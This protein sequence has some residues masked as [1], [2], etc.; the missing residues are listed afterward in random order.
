MGVVSGMGRGPMFPPRARRPANR[1]ALAD[2]EGV[3]I[4]ANMRISTI[5]VGETSDLP[6][7]GVDGD[8]ILFYEN[9]TSQLNLTVYYGGWH[10]VG[11]SGV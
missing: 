5:I 1:L 3:S 2:P 10:I 9:S 6:S 7:S 8:I 4:D 11:L